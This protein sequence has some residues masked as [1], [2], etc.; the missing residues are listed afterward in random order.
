MKKYKDYTHYSRW[1]AMRNRCYNPKHTYYYNYGGRGITICEEWKENYQAFCDW[2]NKSGYKT[3]LTLDRIDNDKG[4]SPEN[5][6]WATRKEQGRN[7]RTNRK[8]TI[9]GQ[10]RLLCE[11]AELSGISSKEIHKRI[12]RGWDNDKL[13]K[14]TEHKNRFIIF[15]GEKHTIAEWS[16]ILNISYSTICTRLQRGLTPFESHDDIRKRAALIATSKKIKQ[17]DLEGNLIREWNS[18]AEASRKMNMVAPSISSNL[19]GLSKT[20]GGYIWKYA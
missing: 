15:N 13:L 5:C 14:P 20:A 19:R 2:A 6:R 7:Q 10:T 9:Q 16:K 4:Y 1:K 8:I 3:G 18:I 11:W 17:Y 12:K